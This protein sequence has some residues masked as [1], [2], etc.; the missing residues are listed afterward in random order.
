MRLLVGLTRALL[1][2]TREADELQEKDR[3]RVWMD[4][5]AY[6]LYVPSDVADTTHA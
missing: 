2:S 5:P 3:R 4:V 1:L 6:L